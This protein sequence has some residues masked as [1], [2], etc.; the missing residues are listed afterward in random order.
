MNEDVASFDLRR[1][2]RTVTAGEALN[3]TVAQR[4]KAATGLDVAE[5]YGQTESLMSIGCPAGE[6]ARPGSMGLPLAGCVVEVIDEH[7]NPLPDGEEGDLALLAPNPQLMLGYLDEPERTQQCYL[8]APDGR[9]WFVTGDRAERQADEW[10]RYRGRR[11]DIINS[12]GYRIGPGEVENA[13]LSHPR[14]LEAAT[15]GVP[16]AERGEIVKAFIVLRS[17]TEPTEALKK[18][19]QEHVKKMTA[20]YKYPR[21]VEF[22]PELPKTLTGKIQRVALRTMEKQRAA[23]RAPA[24][25]P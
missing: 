3:V 6:E 21:A 4:W 20:P 7:G 15:V 14:V 11:D 9:Q 8:T 10:F 16:D 12:A 2:R 22:L 24:A 18:D 19:I 17:G 1:L 25:K 23:L 13:L 5:A